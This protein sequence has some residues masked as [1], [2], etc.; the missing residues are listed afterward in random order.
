MQQKKKIQPILWLTLV[1][2]DVVKT[3]KLQKVKSW[4]S[5]SQKF[6]NIVL[7]KIVLLLLIV[8]VFSLVINQDF[9]RYIMFQDRMSVRNLVV[10]SAI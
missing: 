1:E 7:L 9:W 8:Y 2:N 10:F 4:I 5:N 3:R 6:Y